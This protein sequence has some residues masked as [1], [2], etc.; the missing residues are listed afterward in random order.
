MIITIHDVKEFLSE[1][2]SNTRAGIARNTSSFVFHEILMK[3]PVDNVRKCLA[4]NSYISQYAICVLCT[5]CSSCVLESLAK[6]PKTQAAQLQQI[7]NSHSNYLGILLQILRNPH[8][9]SSLIAQI[10]EIAST[11]SKAQM[12]RKELARMQ[13]R[14]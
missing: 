2:S 13:K 12:L 4:E 7:F 9:T 10:S 3:D 6:N 8:V 14:S 11:N 5:D 1:L